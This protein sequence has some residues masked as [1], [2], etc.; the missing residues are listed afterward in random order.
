[1]PA[2]I[3]IRLPAVARWQL[4]QLRRRARDS[5]LIVRAIVV[6][7]TAY[8]G[9]VEVIQRATGFSKAAVWK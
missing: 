9:S 7:M 8:Q 6:L 1:M 4:E 2:A 3:A 5:R